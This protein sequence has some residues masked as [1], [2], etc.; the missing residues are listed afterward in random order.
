[1]MQTDVQKMRN[2]KIFFETPLTTIPG[3][4][5]TLSKLSISTVFQLFAG[6]KMN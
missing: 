2:H 6:R 5:H 3:D 4:C 1:M